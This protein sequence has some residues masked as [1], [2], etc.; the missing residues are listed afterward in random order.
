MA[1]NV[2]DMIIAR[3]VDWGV[4]H[5]YGYPGDDIIWIIDLDDGGQTWCVPSR[6]VRAPANITQGRTATPSAA[7][8]HANSGEP[9]D[10]C[11]AQEE[12]R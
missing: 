8:T 5:I 2:S 1:R 10:A 6:Y 7:P 12:F 9:C 4:Q 3:L 11:R